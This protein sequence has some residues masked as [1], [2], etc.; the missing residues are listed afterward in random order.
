MKAAS[1]N[2]IATTAASPRVSRTLEVRHKQAPSELAHALRSLLSCNKSLFSDGMNQG[3]VGLVDGSGSSS[4]DGSSDA[5]LAAA[6]SFT[7]HASS[8]SSSANNIFVAK[9]CSADAMLPKVSKRVFGSGSSRKDGDGSSNDGSVGDGSSSSSSS[10]DV[11]VDD[12]GR[13]A[14]EVDLA[15]ADSTELAALDGFV[16]RRLPDGAQVVENF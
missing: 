6:V 9:V 14:V 10:C 4:G 5:L 2:R 15:A 1:G 11:C 7:S 16:R 3:K 8:D 12:V 13:G